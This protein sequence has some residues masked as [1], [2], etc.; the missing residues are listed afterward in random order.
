[1]TAMVE[2][3]TE[4]LDAVTLAPAP[5]LAGAALASVAILGTALTFQH[6]LGLQPCKLCIYQRIPYGAVVAIGLVG[7]VL[8]R[9]TAAP[10]PLAVLIGVAIGLLFLADAGIAAFHV[11]VEQHW[12]T[13]TEACTGV[14]VAS[15]D[16]EALRQAIL[17]AP[18][19][20]CDQVLAEFLGLSIT[21]WNFFA[22]LG[23]A[24]AT[25]FV[26]VRWRRGVNV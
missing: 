2:S 15:G 10:G 21:A 18:V 13:G 16:L 1:M 14:A 23:L 5:M 9:R 6:V 26:L 22:A 20:R 19:V 25:A 12:W 24:A 3:L 4:R 7:A 8:T 11:G 17:S